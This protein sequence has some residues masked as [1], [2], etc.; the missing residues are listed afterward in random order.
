MS[1]DKF[2]DEN[3]PFNFQHVKWLLALRF[4]QQN[5]SFVYSL[6][7]LE[8]PI[9]PISLGDWLQ[10]VS[11]IFSFCFFFSWQRLSRP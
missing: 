6:L 10:A 2:H 11:S 4:E 9:H 1:A 3:G 5:V 7:A 8:T